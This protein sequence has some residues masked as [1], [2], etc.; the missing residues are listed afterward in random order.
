MA[1]TFQLPGEISVG[2]L[3]RFPDVFRVDKVPEDLEE[4]AADIHQAAEGALLD[5]DRMRSREGEKL[6]EDL[7]ARLD[8]LE[9]YTGLWSSARPRLSRITAPD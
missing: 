6:A 2:L 5:F 1:D 3:S 4:L 7:Q 8:T 9:E